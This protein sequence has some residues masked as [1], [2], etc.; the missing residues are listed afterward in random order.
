MRRQHFRKPLPE[1][2]HLMEA[3]KGT[4]PDEGSI[5]HYVRRK[6]DM[7]RIKREQRRRV[8]EATPHDV[9]SQDAAHAKRERRRQRNLGRQA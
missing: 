5:I 8:R 6:S 9:A 3:R 2:Q 4:G 7:R 1:A